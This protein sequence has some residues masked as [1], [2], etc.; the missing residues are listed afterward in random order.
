MLARVRLV[1]SIDYYLALPDNN[2]S[3]SMLL[4]IGFICDC[5]AAATNRNFFHHEGLV[6]DY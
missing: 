5:E 6:F 3:Y 2:F 1:E 4:D